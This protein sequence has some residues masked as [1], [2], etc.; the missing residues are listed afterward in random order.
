MRSKVGERKDEQK[1]KGR[2]VNREKDGI[3][4]EWGESWERNRWGKGKGWGERL[5]RGG[6]GVIDALVGGGVVTYCSLSFKKVIL[7]SPKFKVT[8]KTRN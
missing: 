4:K 8:I 3:E 5:G 1:G 6:K 2:R 7:K